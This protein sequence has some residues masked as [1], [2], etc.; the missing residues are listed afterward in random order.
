MFTRQSPPPRR[1][2]VEPIAEVIKNDDRYLGGITTEYVNLTNHDLF[3]VDVGNVPASIPRA[4]EG[5]SPVAP[6][7]PKGNHFLIIKQ[8]HFQEREYERFRQ[9]IHWLAS[10]ELPDSPLRDMAVEYARANPFGMARTIRVVYAVPEKEILT[11]V[12]VA[13][14]DTGVTILRDHSARIANPDSY[15]GKIAWEGARDDQ[16]EPRRFCVDIIFSVPNGEFHEKHFRF[17]GQTYHLQGRFIPELPLGVHLVIKNFDGNLKDTV[18][19][20]DFARRYFR[21]EELLPEHGFYNTESQ[22]THSKD[23]LESKL[24]ALK[25]D[26]SKAKDAAEKETDKIQYKLKEMERE[27]TL[28]RE[29][30][31]NERNAWRITEEGLRDQLGLQKDHI[32][33]LQEESVNNRREYDER[34]REA[35][36]VADDLRARARAADEATAAARQ[37]AERVA[38]AARQREQTKLSEEAERRKSRESTMRNLAEVG[39]YIATFAS[40]AYAAWRF[41]KSGE[42]PKV[43]GIV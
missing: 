3:V 33:R 1:L 25:A 12:Q 14:E 28:Q 26:L 32:K 7:L 8:Y 35:S 20:E 13:V 39:K 23:L 6:G 29:R 11:S 38:E 21:M 42:P 37:A 5:Y 22:A 43:P 2:R 19:N 34:Q 16:Q 24:L 10:R 4:R 40:I 30:W 27:H 15:V 18:V 36:R 9:T 17:L 31:E 41:F